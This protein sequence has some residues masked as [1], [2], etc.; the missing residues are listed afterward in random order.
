[1]NDDSTPVHITRKGK[2]DAIVVSLD[3][4]ESLQETL[5]VLQNR[6]LSQQIEASIQTH[7]SRSGRTSLF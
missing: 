6:S 2:K 4:W 1:M 7:Q 5:Y 3:E